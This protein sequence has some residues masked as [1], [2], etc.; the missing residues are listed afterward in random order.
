MSQCPSSVQ[1]EQLLAEKLT[2][3]E[4]ETLEAHV[5]SCT[6]CQ[7]RLEL[8]A[9]STVRVA[10]QAGP[11]CRADPVHEPGDDFLRRLRQTPQPHLMLPGAFTPPPLP[12]AW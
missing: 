6:S 10:A 7:E 1:L 12:V 5:E 3:P 2:G 8:L 11:G 9:S 4:Y